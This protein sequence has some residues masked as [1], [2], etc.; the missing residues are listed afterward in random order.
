MK[1][2]QYNLPDLV[3]YVGRLVKKIVEEKPDA[4][5][6]IAAGETP[7]PVMAK[8]IEMKE[9]GQID[10]SRVRFVGL[11]EWLG[12][13]L[14]CVGSC[15]QMLYDDFFNQLDIR[16]DQIV[17]FNGK[18]QD[19]SR[20]IHKMDLLIDELGLDFILLGLGM[21][22]HIGLNEPQSSPD[23]KTHL[24]ALSETT[25]QVMVKYFDDDVMLT[26]GITLGFKQILAAQ[27]VILMATGEKKSAIVQQVMD[28]DVTI[29]LPASQLKNAQHTCLFLIDNQVEYQ[30]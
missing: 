22:G 30:I 14:T 19:I 12:V 20:E 29:D 13:D 2:H 6:C 15:A 23:K 11:D 17:L 5:L 27:H 10:F 25:K 7:R 9:T 1:L 18:S 28:C 16:E 3:D 24:V 8:L 21:N 4:L 26:Q